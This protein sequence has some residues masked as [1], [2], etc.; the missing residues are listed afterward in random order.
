MLMFVHC[1]EWVRLSYRNCLKKF[2]RCIAI[3]SIAG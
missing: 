2:P 1:G 3:V